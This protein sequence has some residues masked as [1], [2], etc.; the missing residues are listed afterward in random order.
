MLLKHGN[1]GMQLEYFPYNVLGV[2]ANEIPRCY[3]TGSW[4][5]PPHA[6]GDAFVWILKYSYKT[7]PPT[8]QW[9]H[10]FTVLKCTPDF[11]NAP[12]DR[13][14]CVD[15]VIIEL[16]VLVIHMVYELRLLIFTTDS[17]RIQP[18]LFIQFITGA[19]LVATWMSIH[20]PLN[21]S[22]FSF[23]NIFSFI[24][25]CKIVWIHTFLCN[26]TVLIWKNNKYITVQT[27]GLNDSY[28]LQKNLKIIRARENSPIII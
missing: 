16:I 17:L 1:G 9:C 7:Q 20:E 2:F 21:I 6:V 19:G 11:K 27:R 23:I 24:S 3:E 10:N 25:T 5:H 12:G 28:L 14:N 26:K 8:I 15:F 13:S 4:V 18:S 22:Y